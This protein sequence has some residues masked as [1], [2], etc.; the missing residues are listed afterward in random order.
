MAVASLEG[1]IAAIAVVRVIPSNA[2]FSNGLATVTIAANSLKYSEATTMKYF[3]PEWWASAGEG[4]DET[5]AR[6]RAYWESVKDLLPKSIMELESAHTLHDSVVA[7]VVCNINEK[8]VEMYLLGW[9]QAFEV[10]TK[11]VLRFNAVSHFEQSIQSVKAFKA[12][13]G[14]LGYWEY[15]QLSGQTEMRLL[16]DSNAEFCIRFEDFEFSHEP[17]ASPVFKRKRG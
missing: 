9:D 14:D 17:M 7:R 5:L 3:T 11:Y 15:E 1:K 16:F 2:E 13:F 6:Y 10:K 4:S 8:V 12:G